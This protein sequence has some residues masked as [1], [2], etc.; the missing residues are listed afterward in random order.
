MKKPKAKPAPMKPEERW[1]CVKRGRLTFI[2]GDSELPEW[3]A[4]HAE[5]ASAWPACW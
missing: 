3:M 4:T 5:K 1:A 2:A